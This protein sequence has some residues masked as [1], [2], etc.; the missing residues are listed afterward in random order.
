MQ[1]GRIQEHELP[2]RIRDDAA[3]RVA[4]GLL[5]GRDDRH[6]FANKLIDERRLARI[7]SSDNSYYRNFHFSIL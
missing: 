6:L 3:D 7:G 1:S 2:A 5:D 4:G